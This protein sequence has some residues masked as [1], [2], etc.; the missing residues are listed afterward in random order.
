VTPKTERPP[1]V[2]SEGCHAIS[3]GYR[4]VA[5]MSGVFFIVLWRR[6]WYPQARQLMLE[7]VGDVSV[8]GVTYVTIKATSVNGVAGVSCP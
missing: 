7:E 8:D 2:L 4:Q 3:G 1:G 6:I 5:E